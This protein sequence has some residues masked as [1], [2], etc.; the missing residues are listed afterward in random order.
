MIIPYRSV[1]PHFTAKGHTK[2]IKSP[3]Q[4]GKGPG[5]LLGLW[6]CRDRLTWMWNGRMTVFL[7]PAGLSMSMLLVVS[8]SVHTA[9][10]IMNIWFIS[11]TMRNV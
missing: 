7:Y 1:G 2:A 10:S 8:Q 4:L 5:F 11:L 9:Y 6:T 3:T